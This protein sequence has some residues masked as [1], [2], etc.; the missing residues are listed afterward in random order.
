[1]NCL[2]RV[3]YVCR[4]IVWLL[5]VVCYVC[6][7]YSLLFG[8]VNCCSLLCVLLRCC[9]LLFVVRDVLLFAVCLL[10]FDNVRCCVLLFLVVALCLL[11]IG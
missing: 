4:V 3:V 1:M 6:V 5:F 11:F 2:L 8:V 7:V 9:L 10:L